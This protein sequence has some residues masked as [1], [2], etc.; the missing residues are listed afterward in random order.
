MQLANS[1]VTGDYKGVKRI[2]EAGYSPDER[3]YP[4]RKMF[5]VALIIMGILI[6]LS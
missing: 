4:V 5:N 3:L 2:L 1:I 6:G